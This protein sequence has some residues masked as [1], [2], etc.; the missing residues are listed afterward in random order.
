MLCGVL[1]EQLDL[2]R[3]PGYHDIELKDKSS[4]P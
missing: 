4:N 2:S 3:Y 1:V